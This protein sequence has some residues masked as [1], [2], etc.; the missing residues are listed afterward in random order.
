MM[1]SRAPGAPGARGAFFVRKGL[2]IKAKLAVAQTVQIDSM[3]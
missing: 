2:E 1:A 3:F